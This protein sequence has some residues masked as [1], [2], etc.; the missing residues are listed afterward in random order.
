MRTL[1][2]WSG[3]LIRARGRVAVR[4]AFAFALAVGARPSPAQTLG[5]STIALL[6]D[7]LRE[8][9]IGTRASI[10]H[11]IEL[12]T[13]VL[14]MLVRLGIRGG[15]STTLNHIGIAYDMLGRP[16]SALLYLRR[17]LAIQREVGDGAGEAALLNNI[18]IQIK[19]LGRPDSALVYYR[20]ALALHRAAR[21]R[22]GEAAS[23]QNIGSAQNEL[24]RPDSALAYFRQTLPI[25][26][27]VGNRKG[28]VLTLFG[29]AAAHERTGR[30][31]SALVN[32]HWALA[33][34]H[35]I[36]DHAMEGK[37][38]DG[39]GAVQYALGRS[40]SAFVYYRRALPFERETGDRIAE[41]GTLYSIGLTYNRVARLDSALV[42]FGQSLLIARESGNRALEG[43]TLH[44]IGVVHS[45][46]VGRVD[47]ALFYARQ[48]LSIQ[49][50]AGDRFNEG[51]TLANIGSFHGM[52][53]RV[54][55]TFVNYR[56]ALDI[57]REVADPD[58]EAET[59]KGIGLSYRMLG[60]ANL[61]ASVAY[62]DSS[63]AVRASIA[64]RSGGEANR[65][66]YA[67]QQSNLFEWWTLAWLAREPEV[68][69]GTS[70]LAALA[71]AERGRAQ[72][73]L[74]LMRRSAPNAVAGGDL[75]AEGR[76]L[77]AHAT[78]GGAAV[79]SYLVT[80]DTLVI[81]LAIP[82]QDVEVTRRS[83]PRDTLAEWVRTLRGAL[84]V[85]E[86]AQDRVALR[87]G[88]SPEADA[89]MRSR[90]VT[91]PSG[92]A[93]SLKVVSRVL[94]GLLLPP[95][96]DRRLGATREVVIIPHGVLALVPFAA[97]PAD[98]AGTPLGAGRALRYAPSLAVL[99]E[100]G[101][102]ATRSASAPRTA[103]WRPLVV[104]NPTMPT[105]SSI[106]DEFTLG[107]LPGA[108]TE[109]RSVAAQ[110]GT[111]ALIGA[112]ATESEVRARLPAAP[113]VHLATH[114]YAYASE[115]GAR[116][117]FI[118]LA[119]SAAHDGFLTV[120][121]ILDDPAL[122]L[123]AELVVLSACQT[124]LGD[125]RQAEGTVGLQRAFLARGARSVLVSLWS[126]SD[127]ATAL[128]M[129]GFYTHWLTDADR[130]SKAESLRR[131]QAGVRARP[132]FRDPKYWAA[133]QLVGAG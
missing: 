52:M 85:T 50:A 2:V 98:S 4:L 104:G 73:L 77:L 18:G 79:L 105:T 59:L 57:A 41:G 53:G 32:N 47:S 76:R 39:I 132:E 34:A 72:A 68:G 78:S 6:Q 20:Q 93:A 88:G 70:G 90:G 95:D 49:R 74:E 21:E 83:V 3:V 82:G 120:G 107:P 128:L 62:Y 38:L 112:K 19:T 63:A 40:D 31:D 86:A 101:G 89:P 51:R 109:A 127:D 60:P 87:G 33:I 29:I 55:S 119:P 42:Y 126:V 92:K 48:A 56:Q 131:A 27:E 71:A 129:K 81:W 123:S 46:F 99:G 65:V 84:G 7:A 122:T 130:P 5:D 12:W 17:A 66:S 75:A 64:A 45:S 100:A 94:S 111:V 15:Q 118:A 9:G 36:N 125:L 117:S 16:D 44:A 13:R 24:S 11:A 102:R 28:E 103:A 67:E 97:L 80:A 43:S 113:V 30:L 22:D 69:R 108:E 114:G 61:R 1:N 96:F 26:R 58:A 124:G 23:L 14:P 10:N 106:G 37:I 121:E 8:N 35:T 116:R 54:D 25:Q 115:A 110:L 133:F 91:S